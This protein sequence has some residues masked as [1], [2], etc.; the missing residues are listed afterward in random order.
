ML[1]TPEQLRADALRIW[2]A[3]LEAVRSPQLVFDAV[4]VEGSTLRLG[5]EF[6]DLNAMDR[7]AVA[8]GGKAAAGMAVALEQALGPRMLRAKRVSGVVNVPADCLQPT[9]AIRLHAGRP[10]GVNEPTAEGMVGVGEMLRIVSQLGP[11]DLC[12]CLVSGGGSALLPAPI[13]GFAL[14]DKVELTRE[15]SAR[16]AT[17]AQMNAVRRALSRVKGGGLAAAC[18]A[19]RLV[20]L[21]LSDV[22]GDDLAAIS[23]GP[24]VLGAAEPRAAIDVIDALSLANFPAGAKARDLLQRR[25]I[26]GDAPGQTANK[27]GCEISNL[28]IGNNATAVDGAGVEAERLGYSHAMVSANAPEGAVEGVAAGIVALAQRMRDESGPDCL[29]SGGEPTVRLAPAAERGKGG[30]NQQ[31]CLAALAELSDWRRLCLISGGTDGEDGPTDAA[32]ACVDE[33]IAAKVQRLH[34]DPRPSLAR[35]DAYTFF[36]AVG[37]LLRT[38]PT[39]TN[40]CDLRVLTVSRAD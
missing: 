31:L 13:D 20:S 8:G 24:T 21:I 39:H 29:I 34:L 22:P 37:G 12:I 33:F 27:F 35:N 36:D 14:E 25:T 28:L 40:V 9:D 26:E 11:R 1:R 16:G 18:R 3:G 15:M 6:F 4:E 19:G 23:S 10:A 5:E 32:G 2:R 17:I 30:R 38:G 7:I